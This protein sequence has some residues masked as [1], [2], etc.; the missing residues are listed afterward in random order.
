MSLDQVLEAVRERDIDFLLVEELVCN[1]RVQQFLFNVLWPGKEYPSEPIIKVRHSVSGIDEGISPGVNDHLLIRRGETDIEVRYSWP[2]TGGQ[3]THVALLENKVDAAFTDLQPERYQ[4]RARRLER[5][6][7]ASSARCLLTAPA[8]YAST[9]RTA[10]F[11]EIVTYE[12]WVAVLSSSLSSE[13][14]ATA[15]H[16]KYRCSVLRHAAGQW[17]RQGVTVVHT[18]VS[19]F[20]Q[21]YHAYVMA[22]AP[23]LGMRRPKEGGQWAGDY[24]M[25]FYDALLPKPCVRGNIKHKCPAG[26]VD[27]Q[28][29]GWAQYYDEVAPELL[30]RWI[31]R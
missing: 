13:D 31:R 1:S 21:Q 3:M 14:E 2:V 5:T 30:P 4:S 22:V 25:E 8:G 16:L 27:L 7:E 17:R 15:R 28:L 29:S 6:G 26:R 23:E 9:N 20:R 11:D 24:W 19:S 18:G 12:D 10:V